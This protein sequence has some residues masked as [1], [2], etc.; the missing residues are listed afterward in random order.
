MKITHVVENLER[1]G[2]ERVVVDLA[3]MQH[4]Q[5]HDCKVVC[6]FGAGA[7]APELRRQGIPVHACGKGAGLDMRALLR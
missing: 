6:L 7:L 2:L 1:G 5:G 3:G 4:Q